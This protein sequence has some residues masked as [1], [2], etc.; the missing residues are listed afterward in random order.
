MPRLPFTHDSLS[1]ALTH[2][3][4]NWRERPE[5]RQPW[6]I[7]TGIGPVHFNGPQCHAY[8]IGL[9]DGERKYRPAASEYPYLSDVEDV[10][11]T[12]Q[13]CKYA[14]HHG[15]AHTAFEVDFGF[16]LGR[17][18]FTVCDE[19]GPEFDRW[20]AANVKAPRS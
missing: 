9:A 6:I 10:S 11:G 12:G 5:S 16:P 1:R 8:C 17:Q 14:N 3:G 2:H 19:C 13:R 7:D 4:V 20:M 18:W 15:F